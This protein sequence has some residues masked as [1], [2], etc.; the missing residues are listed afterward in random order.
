[1]LGGVESFRFHFDA[2]GDAALSHADGRGEEVDDVA[3][4]DGGLELDAVDRRGDPAVDPVAAG[5]HEPSL[6]DVAEDD[7]T[8]DGAVLVGVFGHGDDPQGQASF[9]L[10][11][12]W[13]G[14]GHGLRAYGGR[15]SRVRTTYRSGMS[16]TNTDD[17]CSEDSCCNDEGCGEEAAA[18]SCCKG[19][20][21][22]SSCCGGKAAALK[23]MT[24]DELQKLPTLELIARYR[25]GIENF[26]RRVFELSERQID[27]AFLPDAGVGLWPIRVLIGHCADADMASVHRMR[28]AIAEDNPLLADWDEN[29][30]V[31]QNLY[32]NAHEG[33]S[34]SA[35]GDRAR[36]MQALGGHMAVIHTLRQWVGQWL[37][38]LTD[39]QLDRMA[40][41]PVKGPQ[42]VRRM[43]ASY[44]FHCEHHAK[45]LT[46][47]LDRILGPAAPAP[48]KAQGG[49]GSGGCGCR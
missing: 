28:R 27:M 43:I 16:D 34:D 21:G 44:T 38:T 15:A 36:V 23:P 47:K 2:D 48:K 18:S 11:R 12:V 10:G 8:E 19:S 41:H 1:M 9:V 35:E 4:L 3:D 26:D 24:A 29:A 37:L 33:Y 49:C 42:S 7:A 17:C 32:G 40:M 6:V 39:A 20:G 25:R 46:M 30:F 31:D 22:G 14:F 13:Q 45:F 5:L